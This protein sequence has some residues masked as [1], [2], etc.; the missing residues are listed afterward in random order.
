MVLDDFKDARSLALP[1]LGLRVFAAK[2]SKA[3]GITQFVLHRCG[4][5]QEVP[6]R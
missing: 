5:R 1:R 4:E 2:L 6:L 3:K